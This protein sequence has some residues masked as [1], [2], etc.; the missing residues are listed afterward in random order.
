LFELYATKFVDLS[1]GVALKK[2]AGRAGVGEIF[3][4]KLLKKFK[5]VTK[6]RVGVSVRC[7]K[8]YYCDKIHNVP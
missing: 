4:L 6:V 7:R 1:T 2:E 3:N 5:K 8:I